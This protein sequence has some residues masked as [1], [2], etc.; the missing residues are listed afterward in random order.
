MQ[1]RK[2]SGSTDLPG[3]PIIIQY[4]LLEPW[5]GDLRASMAAVGLGA[6]ASDLFSVHSPAALLCSSLAPALSTWP[7]GAAGPITLYL[8]PA[9]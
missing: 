2:P 8:S 5:T 7:T 6:D 9:V 4:L 3:P 1:G